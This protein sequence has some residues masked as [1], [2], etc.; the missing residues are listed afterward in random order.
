M[1]QKYGKED[2]W[3]VH[4]NYLKT[5]FL[6]SRYLKIENRPV[7]MIFNPKDID[8][9]DKMIEYFD[10]KCKELSFDGIY[11]IE[12]VNNIKSIEKVSK[13]SKGQTLREPSCGLGYRRIYTRLLHKLKSRFRR[14]YLYFIQKYDYKKV[15]KYSLRLS[16]K[17][18]SQNVYPG[19]FTE[20]DNTS[21]HH[22][23]GYVIENNNL[24]DFK[25]YLL[26]QKKL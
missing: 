15:M 26:E 8:N 18:M 21:R 7:F 4:F 24:E 1:K 23:R 19:I 16:R 25:E 17:Y 22:R 6:D 14:N 12:S 13:L 9:L 3:Q 5:F 2:K 11:I 20:W 10:E